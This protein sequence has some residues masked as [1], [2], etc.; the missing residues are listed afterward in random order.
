VTS[1]ITY[2]SVREVAWATAYRVYVAAATCVLMSCALLPGCTSAAPATSDHFDGRRFHNPDGAPEPTFWDEA[3]VA[4][5]LRTKHKNWPDRFETLPADAP[6]DLPLHGIRVIWIGHATA[7]IQTPTLTLITDPVLFDSIG[8]ALFPTSTV[9]HPGLAIQR[10]PTI[11]VVL[12]SHNHYDHL[13]LKSVHAIFD[14]QR[15]HPPTVLVGLGVGALLKYEGIPRYSELDWNDSVTIR[16]TKIYFLRAAH[17]SRRGIWDTNRTMW[18]SFL[19]DSPEG[20]IYF[21]GDTAYGE[22]FRGVYERFGAPKVSLLPIGAYEPRWFMY[23]MHMN[24]DEAVR[25]HM[26]LHSE[27]SIAIHFGLLDIAGE[28]YESPAG[29]LAVARKARGV[30]NE[31]FSAPHLGEVFRY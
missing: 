6:P 29:D 11:D 12:I 27:H 30:T 25:A 4:W 17:T 2:R 13:D 20:R 26:E 9:T 8:P 21:A 14:R 28:S 31:A 1:T 7:L 19:I 24:P 3:R 23:R 18:G 16:D 15:Q 10:L 22:H 5:A